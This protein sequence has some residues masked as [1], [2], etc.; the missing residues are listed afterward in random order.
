MAIHLVKGGRAGVPS[1]LRTATF[2]GTVWGDPV[3]AQTDGVAIN[4][5]AFAP[6]ARTHWHRHDGGQVLVVTSGAGRIHDRDG[7]GGAITTGDIVFIPPGVEHWHGAAADSHMVHLAIS[8]QGHEWL[9]PVPEE[10]YRR[11]S[12]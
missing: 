6:G 7:D 1:E 10:E 8:L 4:S 12:L 2:T 11:R 9:E 5:V 3:L